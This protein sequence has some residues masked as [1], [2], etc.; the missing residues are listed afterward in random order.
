ML[1]AVRA[2]AKKLLSG[3]GLGMGMDDTWEM[4]RRGDVLSLVHVCFWKL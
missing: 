1:P 2:A 4:M 3:V